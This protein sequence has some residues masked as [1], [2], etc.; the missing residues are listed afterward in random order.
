MR[1]DHSQLRSRDGICRGVPLA[2][3]G[4]VARLRIR[5]DPAPCRAI[6]PV[7][8]PCIIRQGDTYYVFST[9]VKIDTGFIACRRRAI[10]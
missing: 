1:G 10:S 8:D 2:A 7:H 3:A 4:W 9:S 6:R 5:L